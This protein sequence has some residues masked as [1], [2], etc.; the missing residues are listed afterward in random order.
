[1]AIRLHAKWTT[2]AALAALAVGNC[3]AS[4]AR[5]DSDN[6]NV[7]P[8]AAQ[9][10]APVTISPF[11]QAVTRA[12]Y[13]DVLERLA[14]S[15]KD[16]LPDFDGARALVK[17]PGDGPKFRALVQ[18]SIA[19][20]NNEELATEIVI[21]LAF[22]SIM[23]NEAEKSITLSQHTCF[24]GQVI[25]TDRSEWLNNAKQVTGPAWIEDQLKWRFFN[26]G[27][28]GQ[29]QAMSDTQVG[30]QS[31][32]AKSKAESLSTLGYM[33][34]KVKTYPSNDPRISVVNS[35]L[36]IL[37]PQPVKVALLPR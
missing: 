37:P 1:M 15:T 22:Q 4:P 5:A 29:A 9:Q 13:T 28:N 26:V 7:Q 34:Q 2:T 23:K 12:W 25:N 32:L 30:I 36:G 31:I 17:H 19:S 24:F 33:A 27:D 14:T 11:A 3:F 35:I 10:Q 20:G 8:V 16:Y 6:A 21:P 18:A